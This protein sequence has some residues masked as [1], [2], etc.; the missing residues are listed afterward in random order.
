MHTSLVL[1]EDVPEPKSS[2]STSATRRPLHTQRP[3]L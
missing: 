2:R 1:F 3:R